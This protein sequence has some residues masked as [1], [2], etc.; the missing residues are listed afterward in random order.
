MSEEKSAPKA[1]PVRRIAFAIPG[2]LATAT[3]GYIYDRRIIAELREQGWIVDLIK[4]GDGFPHPGAEVLACAQDILLNIEPGCPLIIDGL[5]FAV[6]PEAAALICKRHPLIALVH[7]PLALESGLSL[8]QAEAFKV[9]EIAALRHARHVIVTGRATAKD[10]SRDFEV[11]PERVSVVCPGTD[12]GQLASG[13]SDG[14][15][16][17]LAVGSIVPRK[18]FD[19][20]VAALAMLKDLPW[21]LTIAGDRTRDALAPAQLDR[22]LER[23]ALTDRI[24]LLGAVTSEVLESLYI[25]AD[26]FVLASR[27]EGYGM[28]YAEA[29]AHGLPVVGTTAGA[30]PDTVPLAA[31][32][33]VEPDNVEQLA[34][35]LRQIMTDPV[36]RTQL[37]RGAIQAAQDQPT[38]QQSAKA[39]A[40]VIEALD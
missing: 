3:G 19:I 26:L 6:M 28:A 8:A 35:A 32:V 37:S 7:H 36:L 1:S 13:S 21:H 31:G 14:V 34:S 9:S 40:K 16:R 24:H 5:A 33:L 38:W 39:F 15:L 27:F 25:K 18:G 20:L 2:D 22:D 11:A 10:L 17:L 12:R 29:L 30:I 23:F 4:L